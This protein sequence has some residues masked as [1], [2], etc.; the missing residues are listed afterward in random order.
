MA[1]STMEAVH[2]CACLILEDALVNVDRASTAS[3]SLPVPRSPP[4]PPEKKLASMAANAL[5]APRSVTDMWT[6]QI[7]L[8]NGI[9][10]L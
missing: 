6:V 2:T 4:A 9:V 3:M 5:A 1:A 8:M 7:I 10:S